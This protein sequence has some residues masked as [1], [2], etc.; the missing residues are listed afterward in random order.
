MNEDEIQKKLDQL[1]Q[2]QA[3]QTNAIRAALEARWS[4]G[5]DTVDGGCMRSIHRIETNPRRRCTDVPTVEQ[6]IDQLSEQQAAITSALRAMVDGRWTAA[7]AGADSVEG[8]LLALNPT[9]TAS[10]L[11]RCAAVH[12]ARPAAGL[13]ADVEWI[14]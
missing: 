6:R 1:A 14:G 12:H 5:A 10:S 4:G 2:Q 13:P 7:E 9:W 8:W 3:Y 11:P